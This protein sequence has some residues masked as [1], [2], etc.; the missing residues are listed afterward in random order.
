MLMYY[1]MF[2]MVVPDTVCCCFFFGQIAFNTGFHLSDVVAVIGP[3]KSEAVIN[4]DPFLLEKTILLVHLGLSMGR[5]P[6]VSC[7]IAW[8]RRKGRRL[9]SFALSLSLTSTTRNLITRFSSN[10][11]L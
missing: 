6:E 7:K 8:G 11:P 10:L 3:S 9:S 4:L 2:D 5:V 1:R